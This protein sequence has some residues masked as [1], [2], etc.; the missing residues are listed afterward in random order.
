MACVCFE[1]DR[2]LDWNAWPGRFR[3]PLGRPYG[4][5]CRSDPREAYQPDSELLIAACNLGYARG[6]CRR[7]PGE[8]A[9]AARFSL[10]GPGVVRWALERDHLPVAHGTVSRGACAGRGKLLDRQVE[11]FFQACETAADPIPEAGNGA[12]SSG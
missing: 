12:P 10:V 5:L 4:G 3:P 11:A 8:A 7:V 1:P 2:P 9:D 6:K